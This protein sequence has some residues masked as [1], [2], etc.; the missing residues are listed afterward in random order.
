MLFFFLD[1]RGAIYIF[2]PPLVATFFARNITTTKHSLTTM[3]R[4]AGTAS[5]RLYG[6]ARCAR[7]KL[8]PSIRNVYRC[9]STVPPRG[10]SHNFRTFILPSAILSAGLMCYQLKYGRPLLADVVTE[11][12]KVELSSQH[13]Q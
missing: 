3:F 4:I 11:Q 7:C 5:W 1:S 6:T 10:T 2:Q 8:D 12:R 9:F 13:D